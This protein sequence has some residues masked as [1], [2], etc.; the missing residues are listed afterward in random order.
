MPSDAERCECG[1]PRP[2][3]VLEIPGGLGRPWLNCMT[4]SHYSQLLSEKH[5][6]YA[7]TPDGQVAT[8]QGLRVVV[9][10][11]LDDAEWWVRK[12]GLLEQA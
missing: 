9:V 5:I 3:V 11:T 2:G 6:Q 8:Y 4:A 12:A 7:R 10:P 1:R